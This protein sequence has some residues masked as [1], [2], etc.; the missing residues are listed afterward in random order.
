MKTAET[1]EEICPLIDLCKEG[2]VFEVQAWIADGK[3]LELPPWPA[4][5]SNKPSPLDCAIETGCHSM[6]QILLEAGA[7]IEQEEYYSTLQHAIT[8]Q[9]LDIADLLLAHGAKMELVDMRDVF[10]IWNPKIIDYCVGHGADLARNDSLVSALSSCKRKAL[11]VCKRLKEKSPEIQKQLDIALDYHCVRGNKKWVLLLLWA[12]A[13]PYG[14]ISSAEELG[15]S[16]DSYYCPIISAILGGH[17]DVL[18]LKNML[19]PQLHPKIFE[20]LRYACYFP[21]AEYMA[22]LLKPGYQLN[23]LPDGTCS[24][25]S[26]IYRMLPT[27]M[28]RSS[29]R[30]PFVGMDGHEYIDQYAID[31]KAKTLEI[32]LRYGAKWSAADRG[33]V[34]RMRRIMKKMGPN[35]TLE[36]VQ[37]MVKYKGC[38]R[39]SMEELFRTAPLRLHV[40]KVYGQILDLIEQLPEKMPL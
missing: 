11:G 1:Y 21:D 23:D 8:K 35:T 4:K 20:F 2:K 29:L 3:P 13:D 6:V 7:E 33:D 26:L 34:M 12:G 22:L 5:G 19:S 24:I 40:T 17:I 25:I 32:L 28:D 15:Y 30:G 38:D 16:R 36:F 9:R 37:L 10:E 31:Q 18:R 39:A 27:K 14:N